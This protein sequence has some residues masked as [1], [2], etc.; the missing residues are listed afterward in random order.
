MGIYKICTIIAFIAAV[1]KITIENATKVGAFETFAPE[2]SAARRMKRYAY[3]LTS[4]LKNV[5]TIGLKSNEPALSGSFI[6]STIAAAPKSS[7]AIFIYG[8][9]G[10]N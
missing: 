10:K 4:V 1:P 5:Q 7:L 9:P 3:P 8:V 6:R 2:Y